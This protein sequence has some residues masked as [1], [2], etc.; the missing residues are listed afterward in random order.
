VEDLAE[1]VYQLQV[2]SWTGKGFKSKSKAWDWGIWR[3]QG[4]DEV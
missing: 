2:E 4:W 1:E 3:L